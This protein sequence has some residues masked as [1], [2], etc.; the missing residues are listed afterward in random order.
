MDGRG[1]LG[2]QA[3][4]KQTAKQKEQQL[5]SSHPMRYSHHISENHYS[6]T[7]QQ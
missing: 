1:I 3:T 4:R 2:Y 6:L 5:V 7:P